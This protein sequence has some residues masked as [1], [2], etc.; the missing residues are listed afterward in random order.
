MHEY[1]LMQALMERVGEEAAARRAL[2]VH[3][4]VVRIGDLSGVEADLL[5]SAFEIVRAG[6]ACEG[7]ALEVERVPATWVCSA[8]GRPIAGGGRLQC[9]A[10]GSPARLA[11]GGEILLGR[12]ELEVP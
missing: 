7:A 4:I 6:T 3:R 8:C 9:G 2:A 1:A 10:C 5:E 12:I 11:A